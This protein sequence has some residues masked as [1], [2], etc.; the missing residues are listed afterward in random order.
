MPSWTKKASSCR[1]VSK[2]ASMN[3][4]RSLSSTN[5]AESAGAE[6][7][8]RAVPCRIETGTSSSRRR[9]LASRSRRSS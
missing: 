6:G 5:V 4:S 1:Y 9:R 2:P 3:S 8:D 7:L